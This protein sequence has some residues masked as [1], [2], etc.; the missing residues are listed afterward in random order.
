MNV[1]RW[2]CKGGT[3]CFNLKKRVKLGV[4]DNCFPGKIGMGDV[5]GI[6]EINGRALVLEWKADQIPLPRGQA[7][8]WHRLTK[9]GIFTVL[10]IAGDAETM[11]VDAIQWCCYGKWDSDWKKSSLSDVQDWMRRWVTEVAMMT[12]G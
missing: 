8:M 2:D 3:N 11:A 4:F 1:M 9:S 12:N 10:C 7:I 5:D 6:V